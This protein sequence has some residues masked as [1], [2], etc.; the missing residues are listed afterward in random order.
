[1][2]ALVFSFYLFEALV[3]VDLTGV[4]NLSLVSL[5]DVT[6]TCSVVRTSDGYF[7][8]LGSIRLKLPETL[9]SYII[10]LNLILLELA[11]WQRI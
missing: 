9:T 5:N 2:T 8:F 4:V 6:T 11:G 1:M 7:C 3:I 10:T